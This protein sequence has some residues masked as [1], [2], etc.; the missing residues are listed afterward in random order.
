MTRRPSNERDN[1]QQPNEQNEDVIDLI[2]ALNGL[3]LRRQAYLIDTLRTERRL[4]NELAG[5][6]NYILAVE[7]PVLGREV[8]DGRRASLSTSSSEGNP[9]ELEEFVIRPARPVRLVFRPI[10]AN[11][12]IQEGDRVRIT[13]N[14]VTPN[15]I[16]TESDRLAIIT[17]VNRVFISVVTDSGI[18]T[19]RVRNNL[20][21]VTEEQQDE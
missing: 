3:R 16:V 15:R 20:Q 4:I 21:L 5:S 13:N 6:F 7:G 10:R 14:V 9:P 17:R 2:I 1:Q 8:A 18:E 12:V 11:T 19:R